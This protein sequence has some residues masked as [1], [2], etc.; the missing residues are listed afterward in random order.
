MC[1]E[2]GQDV[3]GR[4]SRRTVDDTSCITQSALYTTQNLF[5]FSSLVEVL[6]GFVLLLIMQFQNDTGTGKGKGC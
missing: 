3:M 5:K 1:E 6:E 2:F 4:S